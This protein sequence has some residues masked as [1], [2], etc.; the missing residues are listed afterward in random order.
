MQSKDELIIINAIPNNEEKIEM[1]ERQISYLKNLNMPIMIVSGCEVPTY[2][3]SDVEYVIVNT[4]NEVIGTDYSNKMYDHGLTDLSCDY[5]AFGDYTFFFYWRTVNSTITKNIKLGFN[6][7][8]ILGYKRVFYTED[9]NLFK[10]KSFYYLNENLDAIRSGKYKMAGWT[11]ELAPNVPMM[12]TAFFFADVKWLI[13]NLTLPHMKDEWYDYDTTVKYHL[14]KPYEYVYYK[15]F[16]N[17]FD[18]FYNSIESYRELERNNI[19]FQLMEFGKSNRRFSEKNLINTFFTVMPVTNT[20]NKSKLLVMKNNT[21]YLPTGAKNYSVQIFKDDIL[22]NT[23]TLNAESWFYELIDDNIK[24]IKLIING[25]GL[26]QKTI[27][28]SYESISNNGYA[29]LNN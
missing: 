13:D 10:E 11:G 23:I 9:D 26:T 16:E 27:P 5:S 7:A 22:Y 21:S 29:T 8:N 14:H 20:P 3:S 25:G 24:E 17:K 18:V 6:A 4:D 19:D 15:L 2:I 1:L 12:C 28:C